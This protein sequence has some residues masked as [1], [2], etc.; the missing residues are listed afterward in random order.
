MYYMLYVLMKFDKKYRMSAQK[1]TYNINTEEDLIK[2]Y[3]NIHN[4]IR[5]TFGKYGKDALII[6]N[7]FFAL[8]MIE[9][10][11]E[12]KQINLPD[13]CRFSKL[14]KLR[15]TERSI[16]V[17]KG[18]REISLNRNLRDLMITPLQGERTTDKGDEYLE[19]MMM[20]GR[21]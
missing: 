8:K 7:Y 12:N 11:I 19:I 6:F 3:H 14:L 18:A 9:P 5:N 16:E 1:P 4:Y 21:Y 20:V 2:H 17:I 10:M 13:N 15:N